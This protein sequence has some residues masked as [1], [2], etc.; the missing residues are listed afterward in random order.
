MLNTFTLEDDLTEAYFKEGVLILVDKPIGW[1]SF[2]VVNKIRYTIKK[3]FNI[4][5]IKV[6]H[7]G[8]LDPL[9][10]GLL[11]IC[12]GKYTKQID[13]LISKYKTYTGEF[14]LGATTPSYDLETEVNATYSTEGITNEQCKRVANS[15]LG[16]TSQIAPI[17]SAKKING[18]RAYNLARAGET[19]V[20]RAR[21]IHVTSFVTGDLSNNLI[22]FELNC[23]KGTYIRSIAYDFGKKLNSGAY[24]HSLRRTSIDSYNI[25]NSY[26]VSDI[27]SKIDG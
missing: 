15:F 23:S 12:T 2:D 10:T 3:R 19:P 1:T 14:Y 7:A 26:S 27:V 20:I 25:E 9:A 18:E 6:G 11:L 4:K 5:K 17:F 22:P 21:E 8:T 16:Q 24:L 13:N